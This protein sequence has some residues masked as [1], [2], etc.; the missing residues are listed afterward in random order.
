MEVLDPEVVINR[1]APLICRVLAE[2][3]RGVSQFKVSSKI[4]ENTSHS[5]VHLPIEDLP[6]TPKGGR[7]SA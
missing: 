3:S 1:I 6:R 4:L 5:R 7:F 2:L